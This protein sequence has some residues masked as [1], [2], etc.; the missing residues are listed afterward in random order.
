MVFQRTMLVLVVP[1]GGPSTVLELPVKA[2]SSVAHL[3]VSSLDGCSLGDEHQ[4]VEL[5]GKWYPVRYDVGR[6]QFISVHSGILKPAGIRVYDDLTKEF[7]GYIN[8]EPDVV[9]LHSLQLD[10]RMLSSIPPTVQVI[11]LTGTGPTELRYIV[12]DNSIRVAL[13]IGGSFLNDPD[14]TAATN[15]P[16]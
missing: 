6:Q 7:L 15:N 9:V 12:K 14:F 4:Y 1:S 16:S 13:S 3:G 10:D 2:I 5:E 11:T 8:R